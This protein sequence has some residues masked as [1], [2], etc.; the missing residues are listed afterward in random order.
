[1]V[2]RRGRYEVTVLGKQVVCLFCR[3]TSFS[4]REV[5]VKVVNHEPGIPKKKLTLQSLTCST[6]SQELKF[7]EQIH[8]GVS[9]IAYVKVGD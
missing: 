3:G 4:H 5:Y 9:N 2:R 7:E 6:C 1:M 8:N